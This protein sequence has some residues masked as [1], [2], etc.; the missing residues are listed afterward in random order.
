MKTIITEKEEAGRRIAEI[1]IPNFIEETRN[2]ITY[3]L[4]NDTIIIPARG[5]IVNPKLVG[6]RKAKT[7]DDLPITNIK[8]TVSKHNKDRIELFKHF[9]QD[10]DEV[11]VATD[12]D[13]EGEVIGYNIMRYC[14]NIE[15]PYE[16]K[17]AYYSALIEED[18]K[19]AF[20][21]L[22]HM[23]EAL[24]TQGLAR[25]IADIIIG[26]NLSKA[27]TIVFKQHHPISQVPLGRVQSPLLSYVKAKVGVK[28][29]ENPSIW[30]Y[31]E[32]N[33]T[34]YIDLDGKTRY[35][36]L[37]Q[38][39]PITDEIEVVEI[40]EKEETENQAEPLYNT[41]D[42]MSASK[43]NPESTM[44]I[45]ESL[46]LKG[47]MTY[48]RTTSR[49][50]RNIR[51]LEE[52]EQTIR[53]YYE[54]P[55]SFS[56]KNTPVQP[57]EEAHPD[58]ILLTPEGIRA[59]YENKIKGRERFIASIV[60]NRTIRSFAPPLRYKNVYLKVRYE[61]KDGFITETI[62]WN[63]HIE[64]IEEAIKYVTEETKEIPQVR[65]YKLIKIYSPKKTRTSWGKYEINVNTLT[66]TQMVEWMSS[67]GIGTEA[68]RQI[69]P[70][71]LKDSKHNYLDESNLP[72]ML[73]ETVANI[74]DKILNISPSLTAELEHE[75]NSL[76]TLNELS[77]FKQKVIEITK[78][79][80][81][82][83]RNVNPPNFE[84]P[85]GHKAV[86]V[87]RYDKFSGKVV[88]LLYCETCNKYYGV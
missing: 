11:I 47:Y 13:R 8:W 46:Y 61:T 45:M 35:R 28:V 52:I 51:F 12:W 80:I 32:N 2:N 63:K 7:L 88:V 33:T 75:I 41:D 72:T 25:N 56:C 68:T 9:L 59:Y 78:D 44:S 17:R 20:Q 40:E 76:R 85:K 1:L 22:T 79:Y 55:E 67:V 39:E 4:G 3:F 87:N 15:N 5:H 73:G 43:L 66:D 69:Y 50:V 81:E 14:L 19:Q 71:L 54:L 53:E 10:S 31:K 82:K 21:N 49:Y 24:L 58:A 18:V 83:L 48:P 34:Y 30:E 77:I 26:L 84:C 16:I 38:R 57:I 36:I 6:F 29:T 27:L 42:M 37:L 70:S 74:I 65:T 23:N 86:L 64:N 60:L 62:K